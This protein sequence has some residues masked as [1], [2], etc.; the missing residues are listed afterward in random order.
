MEAVA[1]QP[2]LFEWAVAQA[3]KKGNTRSGDT[4]LMKTVATGA[5]V[6]VIDGLGHG[7]E[8]AEAAQ[9]ALDTVEQ[10]SGDDL[11][12]ILTRCHQRL[13]EAPRGVVMTLASFDVGGRKLVCA[14]VGNV[15]AIFWHA[16]P[17]NVLRPRMVMLRRGVVGS[18]MPDL[19][20]TAMALSPGDLLIIYTD[21][22]KMGT[23]ISLRLDSPPQM[24]ADSI[25]SQYASG[26]DDA[27]VLVIRFGAK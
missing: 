15:E 9:V 18:R 2:E 1:M 14:G 5:L 10:R 3:P 25:L 11:L 7:D 12:T 4:Y 23:D 24:I 27:L 6:A 21:G 8:A 16:D 13:R 26:T 19:H 22:V 17:Q 20:E